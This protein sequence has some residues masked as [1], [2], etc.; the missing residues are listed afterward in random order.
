MGA[1][2]L[3][4]GLIDTYLTDTPLML[5]RLRDAVA[6]RDLA[7]AQRV[8]HSLKSSSAYLGAARLAALC[9]EM[10]AL[11]GKEAPEPVKEILPAILE[12]FERV[13]AALMREI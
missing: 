10:E 6:R 9:S 3:L 5:E 7:S 4:S 8:A 1:T 11:A 12:E 2:N 13:R